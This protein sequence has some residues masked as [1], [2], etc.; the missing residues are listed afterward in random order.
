[1]FFW[2]AFSAGQTPGKVRRC[3]AGARVC[4]PALFMNPVLAQHALA[5][6]AAIPLWPDRA[7]R[8]IREHR[9]EPAQ[10]IAVNPH[11]WRKLR[12]RGRQAA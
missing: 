12:Q 9:D 3:R 2:E 1:M 6:L 8:R 10:P 7:L 4:R 11:L 5:L